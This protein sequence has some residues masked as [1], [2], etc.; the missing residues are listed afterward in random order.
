M[1]KLWTIIKNIRHIPNLLVELDN[2]KKKYEQLADY[3]LFLS[4]TINNDENNDHIIIFGDN[5][6][7]DGMTLPNNGKIVIHPSTKGTHIRNVYVRGS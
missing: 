2:Y 5:T 6:I 4:E 1:S 7:I 3:A